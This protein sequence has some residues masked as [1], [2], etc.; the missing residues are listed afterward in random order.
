MGRAKPAELVRGIRRWDLVALAINFIIG[1][2]IFGL[3][4]KVFSL[5]G[6]ASVIAYV[7]CAGAVIL[8]VFCFAEV[9]SRFTQTGGPYLYAREAF[10]PFVAFGVGWLRW[11]SG[12]ASSAAL[13]NLFADYL[14]YM[15]P[16]AQAGLWRALTI[17]AVIC[18]LT[19]VNVLGV[20][21]VAAVS[22]FLAL[23]KLLPLLLF[24]AVGLFFIH[25]RNF[26]AAPWPGFG[27]LSTSMLLLVYAFTG[28]ESVSIPAG[29]VRDPQRNIPFA[30][31]VAIGATTLIYVLV[32]VVCVGT[33]PELA[34]SVRPLADASS[35]FLG[36]AGAWLI[37][38]GA[39]ISIAGTIHGHI[40]TSP[41]MLFAMAGQNQLPRALAAVHQRFR[42]P[43][44][45]ICFTAMVILAC[46]LSG[47]FIQLAAISVMTRLVIYIITCVALPILRRNKNVGAATFMLPWGLV[48]PTSAVVLCAWLL[49]N[50]KSHE[51]WMAAIAASVG[52]LLFVAQKIRM[53]RPSTP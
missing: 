53:P 36:P 5:S 47:T 30:L 16:V 25:P 14:S 4:S 35:R 23:A 32:Q 11:L 1:G 15:W 26:S 24:I 43:Y 33:L 51:A 38:S 2:G 17:T 46:G 48:I 42:T 10:G 22:N 18:S 34:A 45:S 29:E 44:I 41:R 6:P 9:G 27:S 31:F 19:A 13:G 40:L 28:F 20:R 12:V 3:P 52:V 37:A 21:D 39:M 50:C 8:I 7:V 49:L